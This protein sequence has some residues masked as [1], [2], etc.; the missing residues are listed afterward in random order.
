M[1]LACA[2]LRAFSGARVALHGG[3][4]TH[5][6]TVVD[7]WIRCHIPILAVTAANTL[8]VHPR[9]RRFVVPGVLQ[10]GAYVVRHVV[11]AAQLNMP[12]SL[13]FHISLLEVEVELKVG[14]LCGGR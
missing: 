8:I 4:A 13:I 7:I 2:L 1:L 9:A 6:R 10:R 12:S 14:S 5:Y 3:K 11:L